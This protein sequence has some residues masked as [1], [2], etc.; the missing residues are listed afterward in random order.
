MAQKFQRQVPG[1][2]VTGPLFRQN[3]RGPWKRG[4]LPLLSAPL[5]APCDRYAKLPL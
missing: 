4:P 2:S 3:E 1:L 5:T